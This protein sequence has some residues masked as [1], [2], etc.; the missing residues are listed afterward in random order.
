MKAKFLL[1]LVILSGTGC[2]RDA[3]WH[4][5]KAQKL[6]PDLFQPDTIKIEVP[7]VSAQIDCDSIK[8]AGGS[9][10]LLPVSEGSKDSVRIEFKTKWKWRDKEV[11]KEVAMALSKADSSAIYEALYVEV[12]CPDTEVIPEPV[13]IVREPTA[14]EKVKHIGTGGAGLALLYLL[15][16]L[17]KR[18]I[19][20]R[21]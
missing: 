4:I 12:D 20:R 5:S 1:L 13:I 10:L 8:N 6:Q 21:N 9:V 19:S 18:R 11:T 15:I 2:S 16:L 3:A 14:F 17:V 7:S